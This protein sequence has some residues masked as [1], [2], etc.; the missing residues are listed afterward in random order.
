[1]HAPAGRCRCACAC[2]CLLPAAADRT[3]PGRIAGSYCG[4]PH[5]RMIMAAGSSHSRMGK[6]R[7][8]IKLPA[9]CALPSCPCTACRLSLRSRVCEE[10]PPRPASQDDEDRRR[11]KQPL[12]QPPSSQ[13]HSCRPHHHQAGCFCIHGRAAAAAAANSIPRHPYY[14]WPDGLHPVPRWISTTDRRCGDE[15]TICLQT[16]QIL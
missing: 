3:A 8:G 16:P 14:P 5:R 10:Q 7:V 15:F 4:N 11:T 1:M 13:H 2:P 12:T 9:S 6:R